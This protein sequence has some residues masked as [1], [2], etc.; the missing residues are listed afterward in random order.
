MF[1]TIPSMLVLQRT[2]TWL[3]NPGA[4]PPQRDN[5]DYSPDFVEVGNYGVKSHL[6]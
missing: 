3:G 4:C 6:F 1:S 5:T 2:R